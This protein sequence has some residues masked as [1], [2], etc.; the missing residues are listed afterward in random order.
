M[1]F[2]MVRWEKNQKWWVGNLEGLR[3]VLGPMPGFTLA[4]LRADPGNA[5]G[6]RGVDACALLR[7]ERVD[8]R[9][10]LISLMSARS[11]ARSCALVLMLR[12]A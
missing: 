7:V 1:I 2:K 10:P 4:G 8:W 11:R 3:A 9:K 5:R 6:P 12:Q